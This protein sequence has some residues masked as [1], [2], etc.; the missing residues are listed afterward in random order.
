[1]CPGGTRPV[2]GYETKIEYT[3]LNEKEGKGVQGARAS[4]FLHQ[5]SAL[6]RGRHMRRQSVLQ[7]RDDEDADVHV[8]KVEDGPD[9][10]L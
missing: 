6:T 8:Q 9:Q 1:M 2:D 4:A 3:Q 5:C 10:T 7:V